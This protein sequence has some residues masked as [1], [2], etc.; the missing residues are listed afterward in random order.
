MQGDRMLMLVL[1]LATPHVAGLVAYL[2]AKEGLSTPNTIF[3]RIVSLST[4]NK[5]VDAQKSPNR[6]VY[7]GNGA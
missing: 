3:N 7:N 1:C 6:I 5:V 2:I 4:K